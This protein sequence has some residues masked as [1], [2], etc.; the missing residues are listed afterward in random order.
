M[1]SAKRPQP[2]RACPGGNR[3]LHYSLV[4]AVSLDDRQ[5]ESDP[6]QPEV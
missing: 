4:E 1:E 6:H 3:C 2:H 5:D